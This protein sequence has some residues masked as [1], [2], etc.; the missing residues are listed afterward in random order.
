MSV[1][2]GLRFLYIEA[3]VMPDFAT[4]L[5]KTA[6]YLSGREGRGVSKCVVKLQVHDRMRHNIS[7]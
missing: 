1:T 3:I 6:L 5:D 4:F 2:Q 7:E